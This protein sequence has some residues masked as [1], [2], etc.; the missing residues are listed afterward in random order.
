MPHDNQFTINLQTTLAMK[1][2]LLPLIFLLLL[3]SLPLVAQTILHTNGSTT[4]CSGTYYDS[5]GSGGNYANSESAVYTICG[6]AGQCVQLNFTAFSLES[7]FDFLYLYDG[8]STASPLI[9]SYS[10]T[11]GPGNIS[12]STGCI[13]IEFISD[14]SVTSSGWT[15]AVSCG[16]CG[17]TGC[18]PNMG[19][20]TDNTCSGSFFDPGGSGGNYSNS[21]N[22]THTICGTA[23]QC[24]SVNFSAFSLES[25]FDFL[26]IYDGPTALSPSLGTFTGTTSPGTVTASSGCLT[27][28][29]TSDGSVTSS[30]WAAS[31]SCTSCGGGGGCLPNIGNCTDNACSGN[32]YDSGG[33]AGS[34]SNSENFVHTICG[35]AGQ[36]VAVNFTAFSTES[37]F[38]FLTIYDGPNTGSTVIGTY[39]GATSPGLVTSTTGCLTFEFTSDG[40]VTSSGW[41]ATL[42]CGSCGGGGGGGCLPDMGNCTDNACSG[43]FYD[44]GGIS[45]NY[46][47]SES[48]VH[49]ICSNAGN[50][51]ALNFTSF[52]LENGFDFLRIYD[53][54][55]TATPLIGTYTGTTIPGTV[56]SSSGCLTFEFTSDGSV[57]S[58]G[59]EANISCA[60]CAAM[61]GCLIDPIS[62]SHGF[63]SGFL[64]S[65]DDLCSSSII[66]LGFSYD[67][68]GL[69]YTSMYVNMNGNVTFGSSYT[70]YTPVGMPNNSTA[71]MVAPLWQDVDTRGCGTVYYQS[72]ATHAIV[73]WYQV[74]YYSSNCDKVNTYQLVLSDGNDTIIGVGNNTAFYYGDVNW[75]TGDVTGTGGFSGSPAT[76]G[77]N[78]NDGTNYSAI[79]RFDHAGTGYDGPALTNDGIDYLDNRCFTFPAAGCAVLPFNFFKIEAKAIE[80][81]WINVSWATNGQGNAGQ[82]MVERHAGNGI[83]EEIGQREGRGMRGDSLVEYGW[84]DREV[85]RGQDYYYRIRQ[86]DAGGATV[87]SPIVHARLDGGKPQ[88]GRAYPNP[89][90]SGIS[91][92]IASVEAG[93]VRLE[94]V[95]ALGEVVVSTTKTLQTGHQTVSLDLSQLASGM[96]FL[97]AQR[98][99]E[100][101]SVQK[102]NK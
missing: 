69:N 65:C 74:G 86:T 91:L 46:G 53:G 15:A 87:Y 38:D 49:T 42:S 75:T 3:P 31:I 28:V 72:T 80:E 76:A 73:T 81:E 52:N 67:I 13:T 95:T 58:T 66:P 55:S 32:F 84:G 47:N 9:G 1:R 30:G 11:T 17:S 34:Y 35:T 20:C 94:V 93:E 89:F 5:G 85:V 56:T 61:T 2:S 25:G 19:N 88:I 6:T 40:S 54:G 71:V 16:A 99:G 68:C 4:T 77:V 41:Q 27:F 14:G 57:T 26:T 96:Y 102:I 64:Q 12:S 51:V 92:D 36:C 22:V 62:N 50:C 33:S 45:G 97:R 37:G 100:I 83:F 70:T 8:P 39:S 78:A 63:P 24:V 101:I 60:A 98:N 90:A 10:G 43:N 59:W 21:Q 23:G 18:L 48:L 44:S 79:G 82:F 7:G 29:F